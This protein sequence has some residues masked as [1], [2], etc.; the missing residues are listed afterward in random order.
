MSQIEQKDENISRS[1]EQ[2]QNHTKEDFQNDKPVNF[3]DF[4]QMNIHEKLQKERKSSQFPLLDSSYDLVPTFEIDNIQN[5]SYNNIFPDLNSFNEKEENYRTSAL[6]QLV[7]P[8]KNKYPPDFKKK[9]VNIIKKEGYSVKEVQLQ[10]KLCRKNIERWLEYGV[11]RKKGAGRKTV[12]P[13]MEK[14]IIQWVLQE[15]M[16]K[17][18]LKRNYS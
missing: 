2:N 1:S 13:A 17:G 11:E 12:N 15:I 5:A 10:T 16:E 18:F 6:E 4:L 14:T 3:Q 9:V 7:N 8:Y